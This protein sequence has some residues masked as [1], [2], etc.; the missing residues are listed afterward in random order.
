VVRMILALKVKASL[1]RPFDPKG[2]WPTCHHTSNGV[3]EVVDGVI[4]I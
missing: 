3:F 4:L 2:C 1:V